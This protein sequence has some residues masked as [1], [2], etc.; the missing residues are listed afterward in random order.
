MKKLAGGIDVGGTNTAIGLVDREG[1][2]LA[3]HSLPTRAYPDV[4]EF[5]G[6]VSAAL[7]GLLDKVE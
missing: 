5:V 1:Q 4:E 6:A 2:V 3:T 7:S